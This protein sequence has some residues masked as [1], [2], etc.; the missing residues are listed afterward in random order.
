M[1]YTELKS[2]PNKFLE[3]HLK[4]V[5]DFSRSSFYSLTFDNNVLF[6]DISYII[7]LSHDFAKSTSFFQDYILTGKSN[8]NKSHGFLSAIFTY[9][10]VSKYLKEN[11]VRFDKN[12]SIISY[13]VVLHHHGNI[14]NIPTLDDYHDIKFN[15]KVINNQINDLVDLSYDLNLFYNEFNININEFFDNIDKISERISDDLFDFEYDAT[16]DNYFLILQFYSVLLDADKMDASGS[17]FIKR[18]SIPSNIVDD[19]KINHS[20]N[21]EGINKIREEA[22]LEVNKNIMNL[23][24][25]N[26]IYSINLPTGI[27]KTLTGLSSVLKLRNRI[28]DEMGINAR[29]I[30]SLP[31]LSIIDQ[32]ENVIKSIFNE[33]N[34][35]GNNYF[36]KHNYLADM[37]YIKDEDME[38]E[39][40]DSKILIEGWNSEFIITT[41]IQLF[42]SLIGNKNSFLRK[43]H[44]IANSIIILDEIQSIPY[45]FWGIINLILKKLAHEYNCWIILMTATQPFIFNETEI[46]SL[47]ENIDYYFNKFDRIE[48]NFM[49]ENIS[50]FDFADELINLIDKEKNKDMMV[51]LNTIDSSVELYKIIK[52]HLNENNEG[53]YL[54]NDGI[55]HAGNDINLI[56]LSTN[57]IPITRLNK[58]K[59]IKNSEKQNII[60]ST[61][62]IEAGVDIDVDI[63]YRDFAPLD[64]IIQTAGRCNRSGKKDKG[65]V[66]VISLIN[67][68]GKQYSGFVYQKLLLNTTQ[69][70][71]K[72]LNQCSEKEFNLK[73]SNKYFELISQRSFDDDRLKNI[74]NNLKFNDIP[75]NFKLIETNQNKMDVFVCVNEEAV[76]I[77]NQYKF[78][79]ENYSGFKRKERFLKIK[80]N[81]YQYVIS[82]DEK[83]FGSTNLYNDEIGVIYPS[84]LNRKYESDLGFISLE[85]EEPMIW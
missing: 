71:L 66:N 37:S 72:G 54:D 28:Q 19:Y 55:F 7:G 85:N 4:N 22:Y 53:C 44:N 24:L 76:N 67:E 40:S 47:V 36:L 14:R 1:H 16:F 75:S 57:I 27:G 23:D 6:G 45:K 84:D 9:F 58:I 46:L 50:L 17:N 25:S 29:I 65:L 42:Y 73:T 26:K 80:S 30:Y 82:V 15:S 77:F 81:F 43:F 52:E 63:V 35:N 21:L 74:L 70:V 69:E 83:K 62:L 10:A 61:Q 68:K 31:F 33:N 3:D 39:I 11:N 60:I 8:E 20:F 2:H 38:Y 5:A 56:Y 41:F 12:L 48:Y 18:E 13:I 32:N 49:L 51:V 64:S 34:L 79:L 59:A 78:I